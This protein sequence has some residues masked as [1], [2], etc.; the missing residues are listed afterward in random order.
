VHRK[1]AFLLLDDPLERF[2]LRWHTIWMKILS[3]R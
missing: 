2:T 1:G 3:R